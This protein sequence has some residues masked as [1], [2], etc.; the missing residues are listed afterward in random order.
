MIGI[1]RPVRAPSG[2][3]GR[4]TGFA[5]HSRSPLWIGRVISLFCIAGSLLAPGHAQEDDVAEALEI[6]NRQISANPRDG[7]LF[8][9]RSR[10]LVLA[11]KFDQALAD[12]DQANRLTP[13]P[14]IERE[15]AQVYLSAGWSETGV[16]HASRHL[17]KFPDDAE[18][19]VIRARMRVKLGQ[20][21]AAGS[22]FTE[23]IR[24]MKEP[25]LALY[26]EHASALTTEDG[27]YLTEALATLEQG[28]K[29]LGP[30]VTLETA[31]LEV[32]LQQKR[33]DAALA[34]VERL[35]KKAAR[36]ETWLARRGDILARAG[37]LEQ[38]REA[39]QQALTAIEKLPPSQRAR[40]N[41]KE[42]EKQLQALLERPVDAT[43]RSTAVPGS[44]LL[45][46]SPPEQPPL[47]DGTPAPT[48]TPA[49]PSGGKLRSYFIAAEEIEWHYAPGGDVLMEPFCG[50]PDAF[51]FTGP[52]RIGHRY[53]KA[54]Y[55]GYTDATFQRLQLPTEHWR[56]LGL[57][58]PLLRADVG[59]HIRVTLK[60]KT[61][62]PVSLHPHGVFYLKTSEGSGYNDGTS[63][64]DK[65]DDAVPPG[66][67]V[68]YDWF[69]PERAGPGP[70]DGSSIPWL[71]HSHVQA[72][73]DSNAGLVG[74]MIITARGKARPDGTPNDVEREFVTLFKIFNEN[75]SLY[76][77]LN[78]KTYFGATN[79][80]NTNDLRFIESNM[81]HSING[82]IFANL[83]LLTM[84]QGERT[85]WYLLG[86]GSETDLHTPHWHGNTVL[87]QGHRTDV[88]ELLPA[89][90]KVADML[91][92]NP[93]TWM[94]H[95]HV[96]DHML[97]GMSARYSV[98]SSQ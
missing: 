15:R 30:I 91:A 51:M 45:S 83:P 74:A 67:Q 3:S 96:N 23:A 58:G 13:V 80:V 31:A 2:A 27:A 36:P 94:F 89:S 1:W 71:Y 10:L 47:P 22:D 39:Y 35:Q 56:H 95:C 76:F 8:V 68:V 40:P 79:N 5:A 26:L 24:R 4:G 63:G 16:E 75:Q 6:I 82:F 19:Y 9:Q 66:G 12:L 55:R 77:D 7:R 64:A 28:L 50:D 32:E 52:G 14:E 49:L 37:R 48:N 42:L 59:D 33:Y 29:R 41:T 20:R 25:P 81:K 90:M 65:K 43:A 53:H 70:A 61:R 86:L 46:S 34:R 72:T 98:S 97:E 62:F 78:M 21:A 92:D 38:A 88:I 73:K 18:A 60:N 57:L 85:R 87:H 17:A 11:R 69:V 44:K 93:G 54:L 84:K